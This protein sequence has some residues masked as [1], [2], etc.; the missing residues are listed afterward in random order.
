MTR[1][2]RIAKAGKPD[3]LRKYASTYE[4]KQASDLATVAEGW[5][6]IDLLKMESPRFR[7]GL[8]LPASKLYAIG[9]KGGP[10]GGF[11]SADEMVGEGF[12]NDKPVHLVLLIEQGPPRVNADDGQDGE[13]LE[14]AKQKGA[15]KIEVFD[16][17]YA[18][19]TDGDLGLRRAFDDIDRGVKK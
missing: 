3:A 15:V 1:F 4:G 2:E 16:A 10:Q 17:C 8:S 12:P 14:P 19:A 13:F 6:L 9:T 7:N 11:I 5:E 18:I